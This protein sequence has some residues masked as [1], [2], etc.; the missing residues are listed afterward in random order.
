MPQKYWNVLG[1][2]THIQHRG[3]TTLPQVPPSCER[4]ETILCL[5]RTG[6]NVG[7]LDPL[8]D[9]LAERH[10]PL[11]FDQ[12]GH[13]RS[14][15]LDALGSIEHMGEFTRALC[16]ELG[17]A[18][19]VLLGHELGGAVALDCALREPERVRGLVL[20]ATAARRE[21]TPEKL[22][23]H[24][25][26]RD[27]K[28]RRPFERELF[29]PAAPPA[30]L[31]RGFMEELKTDPRARYGDLLAWRGWDVCARLDEIQAPCLVVVGADEGREL[32]KA[33]EQ[34]AESI[35]DARLL[36]I[37]SAGPMLPLEQPEALAEA[38]ESWLEERLA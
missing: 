14:G 9:R 17:I 8:L 2:A 19:T 13:G 21:P 7:Q 23:L 34:L 24:R 26:V 36:V 10:S 38:V 27:G 35:R 18:H 32:R 30:V 4:G 25:R 6:G 22:E 1:V 28:E 16:K 15:S 33:S 37:P 29:S 12:P 11:A 5:H 31:R 3:P 20:C